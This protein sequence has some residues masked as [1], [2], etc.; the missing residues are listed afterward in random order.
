LFI[1]SLIVADNNGGIW[2]DTQA[3]ATGLP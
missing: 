3:T 2:N 1:V